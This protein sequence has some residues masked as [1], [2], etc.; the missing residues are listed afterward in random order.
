MSHRS[1]PRVSRWVR[2]LLEAAILCG[3]ALAVL[4]PG[5]CGKSPLGPPMPATHNTI[6]LPNGVLAYPGSLHSGEAAPAIP[7]AT[8]PIR[9]EDSTHV[10]SG[11]WKDSVDELGGVITME[12]E[13]EASFLTVLPNGLD[14][15]TEIRVAVYRDY[16][17]VDKR[18]TEFHFEPDGLVFNYVALLSYRT[19]LKDGEKLELLYW[20]PEKG[21]W[22][23]S[24]EAVVVGGYATFPI[25]HFSDY[26]TTE[27]VS[28]GGQRGSQ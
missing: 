28:L 6:T 2:Y 8:V 23:L 7:P 20:E 3:L 9:M 22:E 5:G 19:S 21:Q 4:I 17:A 12:L 13:G 16:S 15:K 10:E 25:Q 18:I 11:L 1:T 14:E 26:R 27:R 24:A